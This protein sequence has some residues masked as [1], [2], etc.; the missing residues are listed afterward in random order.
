MNKMQELLHGIKRSFWNVLGLP[1][2]PAFIL[3]PSLRNDFSFISIWAMF[4]VYGI[5]YLVIYKAFEK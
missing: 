2:A 5:V 3:Y 1:L 4:F